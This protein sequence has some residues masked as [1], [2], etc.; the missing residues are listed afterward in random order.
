MLLKSNLFSQHPNSC[1]LLFLSPFNNSSFRVNF[2]RKVFISTSDQP[3]LHEIFDTMSGDISQ[4][5]AKL[6][7]KEKVAI[8][9]SQ[10]YQLKLTGKTC[11][12]L[13]CELLL[14][15]YTNQYLAFLISGHKQI[16]AFLASSEVQ[17]SVS[18]ITE[19]KILCY[20]LILVSLTQN[21][22]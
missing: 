2:P 10:V 15:K 12:C 17:N 3:K 5:Y 20:L 4:N 19:L 21:T 13:C 18:F 6:V 9:S 1:W 7:D 16:K 22:A 8:K 14:R 11:V